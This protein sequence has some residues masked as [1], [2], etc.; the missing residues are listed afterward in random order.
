MKGQ[1]LCCLVF[2]IYLWKIKSF[3]QGVF[4]LYVWAFR[5]KM[6]E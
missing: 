4:Q 3:N 2:S 6:I 5:D 1:P